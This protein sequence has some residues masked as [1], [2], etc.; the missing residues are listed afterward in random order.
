MSPCPSN[1]LLDQTLRSLLQLCL[2]LAKPEN[3]SGHSRI[4][5]VNVDCRLE[6]SYDAKAL[7]GQ[8]TTAPF[9]LWEICLLTDPRGAANAAAVAGLWMAHCLCSRVRR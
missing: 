3:A 6:R 8:S 1:H 2:R 5:V 7:R 4:G 9:A